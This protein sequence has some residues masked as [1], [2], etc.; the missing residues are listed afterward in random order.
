MVILVLPRSTTALDKI[1]ILLLKS[2]SCFNRLNNNESN[3]CIIFGD[4]N[5]R[6]DTKLFVEVR[7]L[8][9]QVLTFADFLTTIEAS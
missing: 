9:F 6:L 3:H 7:Q 1:P 2:L 4:F 8:P 5:T